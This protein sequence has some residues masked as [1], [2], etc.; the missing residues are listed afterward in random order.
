MRIERDT[1][2][3]AICAERCSD[4]GEM[5]CYTLAERMGLAFPPE[6]CTEPSCKALAEAVVVALTADGDRS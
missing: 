3:R 6:T 2:L 5:P 4:R 1:I